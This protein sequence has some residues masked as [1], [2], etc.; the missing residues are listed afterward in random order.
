M[1]PELI[2]GREGFQSPASELEPAI[3]GTISS[4][5]GTLLLNSHH[6]VAYE[7]MAV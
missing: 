2:A 1:V 3:A 7:A 6:G 5:F 4:A